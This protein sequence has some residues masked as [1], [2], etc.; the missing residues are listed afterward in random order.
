MNNHVSTILIVDDDEG[1]AIL[2]RENL[3]AAGLRNRIEHFRDGQ[4]VLDFLAQRRPDDRESY[5]VLLDIRMPKLDGI[6][7]LRRLKADPELS[8]LPVIMLTTT[9]DAREIERCYKLGCNVYIQKP[10]DYDRFA[11]AI[12]RLGLFVPLLLIPAVREH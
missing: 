4:A 8:T 10:V 5:L 3:E 7:V 2:I 12:R 6:E 11:E 1:H 9:D